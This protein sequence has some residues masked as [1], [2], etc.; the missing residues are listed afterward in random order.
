[1]AIR[2]PASGSSTPSPRVGNVV[3]LTGD[4]HSSWG[5]EL[6][7]DPGALIPWLANAPPDPPAIGLV[8]AKAVEFV[9]PSVTSTGFP[10]GTTAL[11]RRVFALTDPHIRYF[12]GE[13]HGY[14]LLDITRERCQAEWWY[15]DSIVQA[16]AGERFGQALYTRAGENRLRSAAGPSEPRSGAPPLAP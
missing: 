5:I 15:V 3:V 9:S 14:V 4:I 12:Q 8:E 16:D 10:A 6:Y 11:L 1:M 2:P 7:R 13:D